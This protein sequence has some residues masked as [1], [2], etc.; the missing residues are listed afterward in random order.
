MRTF[1]GPQRL[2]HSNEI[3]A[4]GSPLQSVERDIRARTADGSAE[5]SGRAVPGETSYG[6]DR[7]IFRYPI[8]QNAID[9]DAYRHAA[10]QAY[11]PRNLHL[12]WQL[13]WAM[14]PV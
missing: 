5:S 6:I 9:R 1:S 12:A 11:S 2:L 4:S 13:R 8:P 10:A 7:I 3:A 14:T